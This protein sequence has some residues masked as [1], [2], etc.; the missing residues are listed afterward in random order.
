MPASPPRIY[1]DANVILAYIGNE[2]GRADIVQ[3]LLQEARRGE[4]AIATSVLSIAEVS[5]GAHERDH[6]LTEAGEAAIEELWTPA[7]P[8]RLIDVTPALAGRTRTLIRRAMGDGHGI[9]G[10]DGVHLASAVM[11]DCELIFTYEDEAHRTRWQRV[12]GITVT[13]PYTN[14][15]QLDL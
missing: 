14:R 8:I 10:A 5:F 7:S 9:Q 4:I 2:A 13:E 3:T 12:T 15:P 6:G 1:L 11:F